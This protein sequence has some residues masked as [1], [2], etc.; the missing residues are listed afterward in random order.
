MKHYITYIICMCV[1][2]IDVFNSFKQFYLRFSKPADRFVS[3]KTTK[4]ITTVPRSA[5]WWWFYIPSSLKCLSNGILL[6]QFLLFG[7]W[8]TSGR[9]AKEPSFRYSDN[10]SLL[11]QLLQ[12]CHDIDRDFRSLWSHSWNYQSFPTFANRMEQPFRNRR[13]FKNTALKLEYLI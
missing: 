10:T 2:T 9:T 6:V 7:W 4:E 13:K 5:P 8:R 11:F 3:S 1:R 12:E